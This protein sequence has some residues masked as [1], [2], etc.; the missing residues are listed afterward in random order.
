VD[1][2]QYQVLCCLTKYSPLLARLVAITFAFAHPGFHL[3]SRFGHFADQT[4]GVQQAFAQNCYG[5][6]FIDSRIGDVDTSHFYSYNLKNKYEYKEVS[7]AFVVDKML[8]A[9][10]RQFEHVATS[11]CL[12]Y[13]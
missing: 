7:R 1:R 11:A 5:R 4:Y 13:M 2:P 3:Q 8:S 10:F 12:A 6:T 9:D